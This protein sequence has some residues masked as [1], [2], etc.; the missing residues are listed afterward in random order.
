MTGPQAWLE[1]Q[2]ARSK[3]DGQAGGAPDG[4]VSGWT[5]NEGIECLVERG[6]A[7]GEQ[8]DTLRDMVIEL[9]RQGLDDSEITETWDKVVGKTTPTRPSEPWTHAR[10]RRFLKGAREKEG[11]PAKPADELEGFDSIEFRTESGKKVSFKKDGKKRKAEAGPLAEVSLLAMVRDG[12]PDPELLCGGLL[13]ANGLHCISGAPDC[14]KTSVALWWALQTAREGGVVLILDQEGGPEVT[15]DK[16]RTA[17]ATA[18]DVAKIHYVPDPSLSWT[19]AD[20]LRLSATL[21]E[22]RPDLVLWDSS[23]AFLAIAGLDENDAAD[24]TRF[25][26][27]WLIPCARELGAAVVV[28]DH[29]VKSSEA[30]RYARGSGAKLA[31]TEV[32]MKLEVVTPFTRTQDGMLRLKVTKDRRGWLNRAWDIEVKV[33]GGLKFGFSESMESESSGLADT[34]KHV[35]SVLT[36]ERL[37]TGQVTAG[38]VKKYG[39][40]T[41]KTVRRSLNKLHLQELVIKTDP[42]GRGE[43][44]FWQVSSLVTRT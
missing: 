10:M 5:F 31:A 20:N 39:P 9:V 32:M 17:G 24:V 23:A 15:A 1:S 38:L 22:V 42:A 3:Q 8:H 41:E 29:D 25:W 35:L 34:D 14:G 2:R 33:R 37:S 36:Q 13:Y 21:R 4:P 6:V 28:I 11:H 12:V 43:S 30:S 16:L 7:K 40:L 18:G 44:A 19:D 26:S 27:A